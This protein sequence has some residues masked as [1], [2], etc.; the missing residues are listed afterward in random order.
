MVKERRLHKNRKVYPYYVNAHLLPEGNG[1][2][3][4][5][6]GLHQYHDIF[7]SG[8]ST[9]SGKVTIGE[10]GGDLDFSAKCYRAV[11]MPMVSL[12]H[13]TSTAGKTDSEV[14][15]IPAGIICG[16]MFI[17]KLWVSAD[18]AP[19]AGKSLSVTLTNAVSTMSIEISGAEVLAST[20][21]N[22][23]SF[24]VDA[25]SLTMRYTSSA[26]AGAEAAGIGYEWWYIS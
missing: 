23:I 16:D 1:V 12:F 3:D 9:L 22:K 25:Q 5:G 20:T 15:V 26:S 7:I 10:M 11:R 18:Q 17:N 4:I 8:T 19:G 21:A 14:F 24:D 6:D 13:I 2:F